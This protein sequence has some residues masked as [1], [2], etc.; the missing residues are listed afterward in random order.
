VLAQDVERQLVLLARG[1]DAARH[2][3][4]CRALLENGCAFLL[5]LLPLVLLL[6][7]LLWWWWLLLH[8][9]M[10]D[11]GV[12]AASAGVCVAYEMSEPEAFTK[13]PGIPVPRLPAEGGGILKSVRTPR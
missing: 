11:G 6:L 3:C 1:R 9:A 4:V 8:A 12:W 13:D 7:F 5:L 10:V 2:L